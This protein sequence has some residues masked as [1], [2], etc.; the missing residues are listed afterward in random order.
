MGI[1]MFSIFLFNFDK[2][3]FLFVSLFIFVKRE[4]SLD[5]IKWAGREDLKRSG[6]A[7][8]IVSTL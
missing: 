6:G 4:R 7:E 1:S 8:T 3:L 2:V 5:M